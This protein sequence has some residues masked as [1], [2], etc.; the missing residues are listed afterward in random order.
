MWPPDQLAWKDAVFLSPHKLIGGPG[1][2]GVLA[3]RRDLV[4]DA[5]P[6]VPGGGTVAYVNPYEHVYGDDP[7]TREEGGTPDIVGSI[8]AGLVFQLK[9]AVGVAV[10]RASECALLRRAV[11]ACSGTPASGIRA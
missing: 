4:R 6:T 11:E 8:R 2:P 9:Q 5:V 3:I 10:I 1:T 7:V